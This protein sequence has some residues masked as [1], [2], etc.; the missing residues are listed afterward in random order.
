MESNYYLLREPSGEPIGIIKKGMGTIHHVMNALMDH[1][2][3][4]IDS[5]T[6]YRTP[7]N[8]WDE[9]GFTAVINGDKYYITIQS[10]NTY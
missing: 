5:I 8:D 2:D 3:A 10:I 4:D 6:E 7:E 9:F 1:F